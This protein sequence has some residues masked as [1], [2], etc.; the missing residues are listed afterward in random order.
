[1]ELSFV[2]VVR[3]RFCVR[4]FNSRFPLLTSMTGDYDD[5]P[6]LHIGSKVECNIGWVVMR[7]SMGCYASVNGMFDG[8]VDALLD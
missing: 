1:M 3:P 5:N 8:L 6:K 7:R 2:F 4:A